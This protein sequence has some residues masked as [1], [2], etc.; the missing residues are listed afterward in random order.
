MTIKMGKNS[1]AF[2]TGGWKG[3]KEEMIIPKELNQMIKESLGL[4]E[5]NIRDGLGLTDIF[6]II[7]ECGK[8]KKH[9]PPWM[10]VSARLESDD[11]QDIKKVMRLHEEGIV[12][13]I[14][15]MIESYPAFIT[16]GDLGALT[17]GFFER[18]EC[19]NL[20]P[21]IEYRGRS[22]DPRGCALEELKKMQTTSFTL[23]SS[24]KYEGHTK[25]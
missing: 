1:K 11:V 16:T 10:H 3:R 19:G 4:D 9:I 2:T 13:F 22:G 8:K 15:P 6:S 17:T 21:T 18:C 25:V 12:A 5:F 24:P 23:V 20:G 14:T 7:M